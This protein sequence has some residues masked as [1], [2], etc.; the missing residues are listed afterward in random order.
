MSINSDSFKWGFNISLSIINKRIIQ[1]VGLVLLTACGSENGAVNS[2]EQEI[3]A[4]AAASGATYYSDTQS[5]IEQY[6]VACHYADS[7]LA[8]FSLSN[9]DEIVAKQ[10]A[11]IF[12]SS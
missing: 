4:M 1:F 5:T 11:I 8:P 6:C 10:S 3:Q 7:P 12:G 2:S 9:L